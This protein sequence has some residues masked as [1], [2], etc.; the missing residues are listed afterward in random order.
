VGLL[1]RLESGRLASLMFVAEDLDEPEPVAG[2]AGRYKADPAK[3]LG[4]LAVLQTRLARHIANRR[5]DLDIAE[6]K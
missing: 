5:S 4:E 1:E 2:L 6:L 3:A